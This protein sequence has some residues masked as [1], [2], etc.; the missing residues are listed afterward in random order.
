MATE[1]NDDEYKPV[2]FYQD[3]SKGTV[4]LKMQAAMGLVFLQAMAKK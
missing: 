3:A 4:F 1:R 2:K